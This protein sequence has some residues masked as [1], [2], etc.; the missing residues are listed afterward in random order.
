MPARAAAGR[1]IAFIYRSASSPPGA[2]SRAGNPS[3]GRPRTDVGVDVNQ[4]VCPP[5]S[6]SMPYHPWRSDSRSRREDEAETE[7]G[8]ET[9]HAFLFLV[10]GPLARPAPA[11]TCR[12]RA[13]PNLSAPH[14]S[15]AIN[16]ARPTGCGRPPAVRRT[17][18]RSLLLPIPTD[19]NRDDHHRHPG[20]R[21]YNTT[22][23]PSPSQWTCALL[24]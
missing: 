19:T 10:P 5:R 1:G 22:P 4:P 18:S 8:S 7:T 13:Q 23:A 15:Y 16:L 2:A 17:S 24:A 20:S 6:H 21:L 14:I 9:V 3:D 11:P 12:L